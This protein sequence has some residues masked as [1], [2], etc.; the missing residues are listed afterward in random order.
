[1]VK[2]QIEIDTELRNKLKIS[3]DK[4]LR[5]MRNELIFIL[6]DS[7]NKVEIEQ[8]SRT[9]PKSQKNLIEVE[10]AFM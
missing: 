1:M 8:F 3:A 9:E 2:M 10:T 5:S 6:K 7:L 4:N